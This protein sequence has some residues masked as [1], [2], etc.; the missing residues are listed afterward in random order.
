MVGT[1]EI[2]GV[3]RPAASSESDPLIGRRL[4]HYKVLEV[5]GHGG[6]SVVYRGYDEFLH[7]DVAI[8]VLHPFLA[9]KP[10]CRARLAREARAVARLEH[11]N[12]LKVYDYSGEPPTIDDVHGASLLEDD[13]GEG[14]LVC[15][16][17]S[18]GTL[19]QLAERHRLWQTPEVGAMAVLQVA[20][21]LDHAHDQGVVHRDL[22]P[23]NI[24]V[25]DDGLLKLMDFG[26][27]QV[28]DQRQLTVTGTLLGSPAHMA[29]ECIE[30]EPADNRSDLFSLGTVLY[31]LCCGGLPFEATTPHA[32]L[33]R[34]VESNPPPIQQRSPRVSDGLARVLSKSMARDPSDRFQSAGEMA[35]ALDEHLLEVGVDTGEENIAAV[36]AEPKSGKE[37]TTQIVRT[38]TLRLAQGLISESPARAL[39][40]LSRV[41]ADFPEDPE[42]ERLLEEAQVS[43]DEEVEDEE[44]RRRRVGPAV[45]SGV[46]VALIAGV[47]GVSSLID[48]EDLPEPAPATKTK[49]KTAVGKA[50]APVEPDGAATMTMLVENPDESKP[51]GELGTNTTTKPVEVAPPKTTCCC[52]QASEKGA[53]RSSRP[54]PRPAGPHRGKAVRR[55]LRGWQVETSKRHSRNPL[56]ASW[57]T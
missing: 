34:I 28:V 46:F 15:E 8:K 13:F 41:V 32:L 4:L 5:L 36:L 21:A 29:P 14:F 20:Q 57:G 53:H 19:R 17:V 2:S 37:N 31:W 39:S 27:A 26:I 16:L 38:G 1:V 24:M 40:A 11:P 35:A 33:K 12:I 55:H 48:E 47:L 25:R 45:L 23:D 30:G 10:D 51:A 50:P 42:V 44:R 52:C 54:R 49:T 22:K 6:M 9:R 43:A 56:H 3:G 18:G 7:R